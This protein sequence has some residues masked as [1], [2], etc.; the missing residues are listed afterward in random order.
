[1]LGR[2]HPNLSDR[3]AMRTEACTM[4]RVQH[5][6]NSSPDP[7]PALRTE[8]NIPGS[9][10]LI[11]GLHYGQS[12]TYQDQ[13]SWSEACTTDRVQHTRIS[14]PGLRPKL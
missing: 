4:D 5:T 6:R 11:R 9:V 10:L 1:M 7:R 13:F 12:S 8:F 2:F 3:S 14:S